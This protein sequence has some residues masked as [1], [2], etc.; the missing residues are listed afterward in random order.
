M[1]PSRTA[2]QPVRLC[3]ARMRPAVARARRRLSGVPVPLRLILAVAALEVLCWVSFAPPWQGPDESAHFAYAQHY[4][5]IGDPPVRFFPKIGAG[6]VSTQQGSAEVWFNLRAIVGDNR[7]RPLATKL[8]RTAWERTERT[9]PKLQ[10]EDGYG[11]NSQAQNPAAYYIYETVPYKVVGGEH[12]LT[13]AFWMRLWSGLLFLFAVAF[14]WLAAGELFGLR[15][16]LQAL[17]ASCVALLPQLAYMGSI[18]NA[19]VALTAIWSAFTW[20]SLRLLKRGPAPA[21]ILPLA[22]TVALSVVTHGRGLA[23]VVPGVVVVIVAF[24][25]RRERRLVPLV[26]AVASVGL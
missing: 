18:V 7:A 4:A 17:A 22:L 11:P 5:E 20:L 6:S 24:A 23:L 10:R 16:G 15:R 8:D 1:L 25:R 3:S 21:T 2:P 12:I 14:T 13:A 19:D 26:A 9:I